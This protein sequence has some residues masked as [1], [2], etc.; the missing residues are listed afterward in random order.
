MI[1][2]ITSGGDVAVRAKE[3]P[4]YELTYFARETVR[5][6]EKAFQIPGVRQKCDAWKIE[7]YTALIQKADPDFKPCFIKIDISTMRD[8][9]TGGAY[10]TTVSFTYRGA[11]HIFHKT[12]KKNWI[13]RVKA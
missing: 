10:H 2:V 8:D 6:I 1:G 3:I 9:Y 7:K 13:E 12:A 4:D 11:G 5:A